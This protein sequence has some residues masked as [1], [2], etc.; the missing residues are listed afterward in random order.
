MHKKILNRA[1]L[2]SLTFFTTMSSAREEIILGRDHVP[3]Y[4]MQVPENWERIDIVITQDT[5]EPIALFQKESMKINVHNFPRM[6]IP[7]QAQVARW[8]NQDAPQRI[9]PQAFCGF[10]GLFFQSKSFLAWALEWGASK[11]SQDEKFSDVTFKITNYSDENIDDLT[12]VVR[13]FELIEEIKQW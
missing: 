13:S 7:P 11:R 5:K 1:F 6:R 3:L 10:Q 12:K 9:E 2:L 8:T 4:R